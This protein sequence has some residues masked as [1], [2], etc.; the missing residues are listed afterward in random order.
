MRTWLLFSG[1]GILCLGISPSCA[2]AAAAI[3]PREHWSAF[4]GGTEAQLHV[5]LRAGVAN[6][7][8]WAVTVGGHTIDRGESQVGADR[9]ATIRLRLPP[10][11]TGVVLGAM[12]TISAPGTKPF[13]KSIWIFPQEAFAHRLTWLKG[14]KITLFDPEGKT[15]ALFTKAQI[16]FEETRNVATLAELREGVIIVGEGTS[17]RDYRDLPEALT[18]AAARGRHVLC[19]APTE[20]TFSIPGSEGGPMPL[21]GSVS[22]RRQDVITALD[23]RLDATAWPPAGDLVASSIALTTDAAAVVGEVRK[24]GGWPWLEVS[25]PETKGKLIICGFG[26]VSHWDAGPTPRF[27][28]ARLLETVSGTQTALPT[29]NEP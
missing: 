10:V 17:F 15:A 5:R 26:L 18:Q 2:L 6:S 11:R 19:L 24:E 28:L 14:L 7:V 3:E 21:P 16:P 4:F 20:G 9:S 23:K 22:L 12:L 29:D 1:L 8:G 25:Y 13:E 27:L